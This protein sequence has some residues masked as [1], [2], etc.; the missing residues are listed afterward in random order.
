MI[1]GLSSVWGISA[2]L[3]WCVLYYNKRGVY[4]IVVW[5]VIHYIMD[6][7]YKISVQH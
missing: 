7:T 6:N 1:I 3:T 5:Y 4:I 2:F